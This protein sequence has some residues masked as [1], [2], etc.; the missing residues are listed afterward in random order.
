MVRFLEVYRATV[1][2][3]P[4][5]ALLAVAGVVAA[6][7]SF[8][9]GFKLDV[10]SDAIILEK[11]PALRIYDSSRLVFGSDDYVIVAFKS[12]DVFS[13]AN[14]RRIAALTKDLQAVPGVDQVMSLTSERLWRSPPAEG[15][16]IGL[17][18]AEPVT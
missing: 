8:L 11:D 10:S 13:D 12:D 1:L 2:R 4:W 5:L 16:L 3:L 18:G 14:V 7:A 15:G 6:F 17:M 9:P